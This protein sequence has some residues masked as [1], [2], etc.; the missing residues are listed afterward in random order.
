MAT[1]T[2]H[3]N[4][5]EFYYCT[6][7]CCKWL[8][9]FEITNFFDQ[10]EKWFKLLP[11][12]NM[13]IVAFVMMPNHLHFIIFVSKEANK[14]LNT[15]IA[16]AKRFWAYEIVKRLKNHKNIIQILQNVLTEAEKKAKKKH[17]VFIP[18]FDARVCLDKNMILQKINYIHL[19]PVRGKWLLTD[20]WTIY[21]F[22]S[23]LYY[24]T[25]LSKPDY[26]L[27]FREY[28]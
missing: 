14:T 10:I 15:V 21:P 4:I 7:T 27:D 5:H 9:L 12:Y 20:D 3:K 17:R 24:E 1:R 11:K 16:N 26:L 6:L 18:S 2:L 22:S 13:Q 28:F 25:E 23:A 19:N 8:P